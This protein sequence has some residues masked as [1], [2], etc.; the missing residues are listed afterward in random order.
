MP[1][2]LPRTSAYHSFFA[3]VACRPHRTFRGCDAIA[4][5]LHRTLCLPSLVYIL[6][7]L[8]FFAFPRN[9]LI[10]RITT[11]VM[12]P[13]A[14]LPVNGHSSSKTNGHTTVDAAPKHIQVSG[15]NIPLKGKEHHDLVLASFRCLIADL[16]QQFGGG[17]P[18]Y[19]LELPS[20]QQ[21]YTNSPLK[22]R[23]G[24]GGNRYCSVVVRDEILAA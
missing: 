3:N 4:R 23:H 12:A 8:L 11:V 17:H 6:R 22:R 13:S 19:V 18:G 24:N 9:T 20:S 10:T 7:L 15:R 16:C 14:T 1:R 2:Y 21:P 5:P